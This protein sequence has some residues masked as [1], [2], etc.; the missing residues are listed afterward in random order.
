MPDN[1]ELYRD[2]PFLYRCWQP[3]GGDGG[4]PFI[5]LHGSGVDL[6]IAPREPMRDTGID[7]T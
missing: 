4:P 1:G 6:V 3:S 7:P 2:L 5:L